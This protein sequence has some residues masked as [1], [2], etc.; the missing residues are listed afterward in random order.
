MQK[1]S[2]DRPARDESALAGTALA[3]FKMRRGDGFSQQGGHDTPMA[4]IQWMVPTI[5]VAI[6]ANAWP[7]SACG[8]PSEVGLY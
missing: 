3:Q 1:K 4:A 6:V 2:Q 5:S 7:S 8:V